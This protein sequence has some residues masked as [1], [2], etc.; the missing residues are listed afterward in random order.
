MERPDQPRPNVLVIMVDQMKAMASHLYGNSQCP[1]PHLERLARRGVLY[2]RAYTPHPLCVPA[3]ISMWSARYSHRTGCQTNETKM[4]ADLWHA[5]RHWS[6]AGFI[7]AMIGKDHCFKDGSE[8]TLFD[9]WCEI[10]H[11]GL[12]GRGEAVGMDW[13]RPEEAIDAA[14]ATRRKMPRTSGPVPHAVTDYPVADYSTSLVGAQTIRFLE[15]HRGKPFVAWVSLPDP[16]PPF[17]APAAYTRHYPAAAIALP[18]SPE[19]EF[20]EAPERNRVLAE[21]LRWN[22]DDTDLLREA[23]AVYYAMIRFVDD[24]VGRI[25]GALDRLGLAENTIVA[26]V[27][28]HG[29][30]GGEHRMMSKGGVFYD[31]LTRIPMMLC[32]PGV[33]RRAPG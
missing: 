12:P 24:Q 17:E 4:P 25:V 30:F 10:S 19:H 3:R 33:R 13:V 15:T 27:A 28:D 14:H 16:H 1:T 31:C 20:D 2:H 11:W 22:P 5:F 26:F 9:V 32:G 23:V 29:D 18:P 7:T 21:I 6:A 8:R